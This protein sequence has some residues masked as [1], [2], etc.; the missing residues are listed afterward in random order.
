MID[1]VI[2]FIRE[3]QDLQ[4]IEITG[5]SQLVRDLGLSSFDLVEMCCQ[6]E[7]TFDI[8]INDDDMVS[9]VTINDLVGCLQKYQGEARQL[10][11]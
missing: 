1:K 3:N 5:E 9:I 11:I 10:D 8:V 2:E 7:E 4:D 6:L